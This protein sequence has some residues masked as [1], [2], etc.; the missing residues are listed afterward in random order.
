MNNTSKNTILW[1]ARVFVGLLFIFSGLIKLNDPLGFSYKLE[2]YFEVFHMVFLNP[3][4]VFFS[5]FLCALEV[6]LGVL[7][8]TGV[9]AKKVAWGLLLLIVFF[10]FLTFYSAYFDVVKTCG[11]FGDAIP[12]T[13]W[14]SFSKDLFLLIFI[15]YIFAKKDD[16]NP[17]TIQKRKQQLITIFTVVVTLIF[18]F[19]TYTFLPFVDFLPYKVGLSIPAQMKVPEGAPQDEFQIIYTL[20]N[21]KT[22][23]DKKM[24]D[25]EYLSSKIYENAD[26]ELIN[27]SEP[28]LIKAGFQPK[29]KDL[30]VFDSQGVGYTTEIFENPYYNLVAVGWNLSKTNKKAMGDI[31]AISINAVENFNIRTVFLTSNSAQ[32]AAVFSKDLKLVT[33]IFYADAVPLKSMV[34]SNPGL[35]LLKNGV[36]IDKWPASALPNYNQLADKYFSKQ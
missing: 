32:D 31:N 29:I 20:K 33:E 25:K 3:F 36:V 13:P 4:A 21:K 30:N 23:E 14:Q 19:Y 26:W 27:S 18:G 11:C 7:L 35:I 22:G 34:R 9:Y 6:I 17:I 16:I 28:K 1:I 10:T 2:E 12:L 5:I 8:L 15:V 24:T